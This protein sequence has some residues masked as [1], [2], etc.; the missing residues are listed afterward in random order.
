MVSYLLYHQF[1]NEGEGMGGLYII[2]HEEV[3][4]YDLSV[5]WWKNRAVGADTVKM[6][7]QSDVSGWQEEWREAPVGNCC[8]CTPSVIVSF[9]LFS[10]RRSGLWL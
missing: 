1:S 10:R 6:T 2:E 7:E 9:L 5:L 4:R 3:Q 8:G